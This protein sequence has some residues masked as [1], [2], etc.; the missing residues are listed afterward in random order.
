MLG[1]SDYVNNIVLQN[2]ENI[3]GMI[4]LDMILRPQWDDVPAEPADLDITT[5][6]STEC[7][8]W[9]N[10][11]IQ[12]AGNYVPSLIIDSGGINTSNF[13]A[14]DQGPFISA[15]FPA[16]MASENTA[17]EIWGGSNAYFHTAEDASDALANDP[18]S[19][20]GVTYDYTF[21]ADVLRASAATLAIEAGIIPEPATLL[22]L[23]I[24]ALVLRKKRT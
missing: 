12:T 6:S 9:A 19:I 4:N 1:S 16:F 14:S 5:D 10:K 13:T 17:S 20:S 23:G 11:F 21:A 15:G 8:A 22:L 24:G 2:N 7:A 18:F 3:A